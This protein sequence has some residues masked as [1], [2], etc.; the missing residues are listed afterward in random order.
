MGAEPPPEE[1]TQPES[2]GGHL[3][4]KQS[5]YVLDTVKNCFGLFLAMIALSLSVD[6]SVHHFE[7][8]RNIV[9]FQI[10]CCDF[11][12][13]MHGEAFLINRISAF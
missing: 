7:P 8:E 6:Q 4:G 1:Q 11:C 12:A 13:D 2:G 9:T 10:D 3:G 5:T